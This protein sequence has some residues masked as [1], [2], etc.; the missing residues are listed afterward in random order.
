MI[1]FDFRPITYFEGVGPGAL[2]VKLTYPESQWGDQ[3]SLYAN[4]LDGYIHFEVV[5]FYGNDYKLDPGK[6]KEPLNLQ[7]IILLIERLEL[8]H[9]KNEMGAMSVTI[10][11]IPQAESLIYPQLTNYFEEK[12]KHFGYF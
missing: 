6:V 11:G 8:H 12:R 9:P 3:I 4:A 7:E 1:D 10:S 2:I 5:D